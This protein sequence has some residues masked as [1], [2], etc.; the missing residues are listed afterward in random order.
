MSP[1]DPGG[2]SEHPPATTPPTATRTA[3]TSETGNLVGRMGIAQLFQRTRGSSALSSDVTFTGVIRMGA[4]ASFD[5]GARF[6]DLST[7]S[8]RRGC[9]GGRRQCSCRDAGG[10]VFAHQK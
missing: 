10:A 4:H 9:A 5:D 7:L 1:I 2:P 8:R 6:G 3:E